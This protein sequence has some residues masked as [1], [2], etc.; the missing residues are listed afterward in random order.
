MQL[1]IEYNFAAFLVAVFNFWGVKLVIL[2]PEIFYAW[3][4]YLVIF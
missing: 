4:I 3:N 1:I 2:H